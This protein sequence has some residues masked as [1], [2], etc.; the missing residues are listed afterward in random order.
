MIIQVG[1]TGFNTEAFVDW[2][3]EDFMKS[4]G[5]LS[6]AKEAWDKIKKNNKSGSKTSAPAA[7]SKKGKGKS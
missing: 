5:H 7:S 2:S 3:K 4:Y 1:N 6:Y